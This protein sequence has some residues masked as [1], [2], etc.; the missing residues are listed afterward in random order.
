MGLGL[1]IA[2]DLVTAHGG[3]LDVESFPGQGSC[4][5]MRLPLE[6]PA[7]LPPVDRA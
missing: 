5:T 7:A 1:T 6:S 4:F 3:R 2:R